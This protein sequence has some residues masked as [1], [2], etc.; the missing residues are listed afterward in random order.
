MLTK[1]TCYLLAVFMLSSRSY[2]YSYKLTA[3]F[4]S[5][6]HLK[7]EIYRALRS[8]KLHTLEFTD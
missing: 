6:S 4:L 7:G 3:N 8:T 1:I 2:L 5:Y